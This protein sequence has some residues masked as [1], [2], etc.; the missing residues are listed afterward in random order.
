MAQKFFFL[1]NE[2]QAN[3]QSWA[4]QSVYSDIT[5]PAGRATADGQTPIYIT[6]LRGMALGRNGARSIRLTLGGSATDFYTVRQANNAEG[7]PTWG[8]NPS[9]VLGGGVRRFSITS[10]NGS[11]WFGRGG[12]GTTTDNYGTSYSGGLGGTVEYLQAPG[13]P[14]GIT[15]RPSSSVSNRLDV[16]LPTGTDNGGIGINGYR[17]FYARD[18]NKINSGGYDGYFDTSGALSQS[19]DGLPMGVVHYFRVGAKNVV[20]AA[21]GPGIT[22]A[23]SPVGSATPRGLPSPPRNLFAV[24]NPQYIDGALLTW[25]APEQT[26]G[27][28]TGYKVFQNG[29]EVASTLGISATIFDLDP[30]QN[31]NFVVRALNEFTAASKLLGPPS[32]VASLRPVGVP[33]APT[34]VRAVADPLIPGRVT[35]SWSEPLDTAGGIVKYSVY[36]RDGLFIGET[37]NMFLDVDNLVPGISQSFYVRAWNAIGVTA[38][39]YG[40]YSPYVSAIP[41]GDPLPPASSSLRAIAS[42]TVAGRITLTW[43]LTASA[44]SYNVYA[45]GGPQPLGLIMNTRGTQ[46]TFDNLIPGVRYS[47]YIRSR[48]AYTNSIGVEGGTRATSASAVPLDTNTQILAAT[49]IENLTNKVYNGT[50]TINV[51]SSTAITYVKNAPDQAKTTVPAVE[52]RNITHTD[53]SV[54]L[55]GT[56]NITSVPTPTSFTYARPSVPVIPA[57]TAVSAGIAT[58]RTNEAFNT[59]PGVPAR[60]TDV[61]NF[62]AAV[63]YT[64][65][66]TGEVSKR[67]STAGTVTN[68]TNTVF[69][70]TRIPVLSVTRNTVTYAKANKNVAESS[71]SGEITDRTNRDVYNGIYTVSAVPTYDSFQYVRDPDGHLGKRANLAFN[72]RMNA[73]DG[74]TTVRQNFCINPRGLGAIRPYYLAESQVINSSIGI[75]DHP[76]G[77]TKAFRVSYELGARLPGLTLA[78]NLPAGTYTV[79]MWIK[80]ESVSPDSRQS[81]ASLNNVSEERYPVPSGNDWVREDWTQQI[82]EGASI[83]FRIASVVGAGGS[84]LV[85]G[86][87]VENTNRVDEYFDGSTVSLGASWAG[88]SD[89]SR[90]TITAP[91]PASL[92]TTPGSLNYQMFDSVDRFSRARALITTPQDFDLLFKTAPTTANTH[93]VIA[94]M[95]ANRPGLRLSPMVRGSVGTDFEVP[96]EWTSFSFVVRRNVSVPATN[97]TGFTN[98]GT[99]WKDTDWVDITEIAVIEGEYIGPFFDG[100]TTNTLISSF[101]WATAPTGEQ[102]GVQ[103][104]LSNDSDILTPLGDTKRV[105]SQAQLNVFYRSGWAG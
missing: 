14:S 31:Y 79:S 46:V 26:G 6:G 28:I 100:Q 102:Y 70:G 35:V 105:S 5:L 13:A 29:V 75:S 8:C 60:V 62:N 76:A 68:V 11:F 15:V 36:N 1:A 98:Y 72:P 16:T 74:N 83:G 2:G 40:M 86:I 39:K 55:S 94:R 23:W 58:D 32:N 85:S 99:N 87:L 56:Y 3:L 41:S 81:F 91:T 19:I 17:I 64:N 71:A 9:V 80:H 78:S 89:G 65:M 33:S 101:S 49:P 27:G 42:P 69:N 104:F 38:D 51:P 95:R 77:L 43:A 18:L 63:S 10:T 84:F 103:T 44:S 96:T 93:T 90:S 50:Y 53:P 4:E 25:T 34:S 7:T 61:D 66:N 82:K 21:L 88:D 92:I 30:K 54:G 47:Y 73:T 59:T 52:V 12:S 37:V 22:G 24:Q 67:V 20:T 97:E 45:S 48:S 57:D